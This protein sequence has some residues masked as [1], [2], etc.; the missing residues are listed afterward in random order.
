MIMETGVPVLDKVEFDVLGCGKTRW[1]LTT[2][3]PLYNSKG[4]CI[5]TFGSSRDITEIKE[6]DQEL[7]RERNLFRN[8]IDHLPDMIHAEDVEGRFILNNKAHVAALK[9]HSPHEL[10]GKSAS[11]FYPPELAEQY[12]ETDRSVID[13]QVPVI[14]LVEPCMGEDGLAHW[15]AT[16]KVPLRDPNGEVSGVLT[17]TRDITHLRA[18]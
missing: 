13:S 16:T 10:L 11:D 14:D 4:E 1:V 3:M 2:K 17:I 12:R 9:A 8:T 6:M 5:G 7:S 18:D 15:I